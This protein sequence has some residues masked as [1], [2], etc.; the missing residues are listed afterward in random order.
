MIV[1][2]RWLEAVLGR[3]LVAREVAERLAM[4]CAAVSFTV[5]LGHSVCVCQAS[6][7]IPAR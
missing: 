1:S 5:H 4:T 3:S 2:R 7:G 6:A